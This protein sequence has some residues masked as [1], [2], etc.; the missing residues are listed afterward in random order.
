MSRQFFLF[1]CLILAVVVG[2]NCRAQSGE[3]AEDFIS[4]FNGENLKGWINVNGLPETWR[5]RDGILV[6]SGEPQGFIRTTTIFENFVL[7]VEWRHA[8]AGGNSGIFLHADA[9]PEPGA[10]SP[11]CIEAQLLDGDHGSLFGIRGASLTPLTNPDKKGNNAAARPLE[12]RC[13]PAGQWNRYMLTS[14]DGTIELAVNGK[15]V[16]GAKGTSQ[17]KGYIGLQSEHSEVHFRSIRI[18]PLASSHPDADQIATAAASGWRAGVSARRITPRGPMWM[19]GYAGRSAPA[20][21][22]EHDLWAK[23]LAIEDPIGHR[24]VLVTLDL[25]GIDRETSARVCESVEKKYGLTRDRIALNCSHTHCGPAVGRNLSGLFFFQDSD[26]QMV[27]AYTAWLRERILAAVD[28]AIGELAPATLTW[29]EGISD[30]AVNRRTNPHSEVLRRRLNG[31]LHGP[32]DHSVP[33]LCVTDSD[34]KELAIVFGYACH[35]T[36][37]SAE[38]VRW[39]GDYA[40]FAQI[41]I[42]NLHPG[43]VAMFWQGCGGDQT[44]WPRGGADVQQT[45]LV[46][47]QLAAAVEEILDQQLMPIEGQLVTNY[48]ELNLPL[49]ALPQREV[50][51]KIA[52]GNNLFRARMARNVL[53]TLDAGAEPP[54]SYEG[55]PV[56]IWRLGTGPRW[57]FLGGE[58]VVDYALRFKQEF[59]GSTWVAGYSNDVMAY[60]PSARVLREGGYE[61]GSAMVYYGLPTPWAAGIEQAIAAEVAGAVNEVRSVSTQPTQSQ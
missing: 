15:V 30:I 28:E 53:A 36:K 26:R 17:R 14:R 1:V 5:V 31:T 54:R 43:A 35:P 22:T 2:G 46:G 34:H 12:N 49:D 7:E 6:C 48:A 61:G 32:S 20:Q 37:L 60:I 39:C 29:G 13:R 16:T 51:M 58:V 3:D 59:G 44:P 11:R 41:E 45:R 50:V 4:L 25:V 10:P 57:I 18:R 27:D 38:F 8:A 52:R 33:V 21:E 42:E 55:Y 47:Q 19:S 23:T 56:Q 24:A 40:G 9:F